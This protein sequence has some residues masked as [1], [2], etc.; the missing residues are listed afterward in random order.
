MA[1]APRTGGKGKRYLL[2]LAQK[3]DDVKQPAP[4]AFSR[5]VDGVLRLGGQAQ[6]QARQPSRNDEVDNDGGDHHSLQLHLYG[7]MLGRV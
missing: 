3:V 2:Q 4:E 5:L 7:A 1:R 6:G